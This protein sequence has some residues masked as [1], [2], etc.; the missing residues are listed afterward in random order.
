M[1]DQTISE[2]LSQLADRVPAPG[3]G[4]AA[5]LHAAQGAAL[6]GMVA[7]YTTGEKYAEHRDAV[8]RII[9]RTDTVRSA[10]LRVGEEDAAAFTAVI[11]AYRLP[12]GERA[13]A[14]AHAL[15]GAARPPAE[16]VGLARAVVELATEL[17]PIGNR[18]VITDIAAATEA[19]RA[20]ATT[21]RINVEINLGG[22]KDEALRAELTAVIATVDDIADRAARLTDAVRL[23]IAP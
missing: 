3:G 18:N 23:E 12:K 21:A 17:L 15:A 16:V 1:R 2:Y 22:I 19:A 10:A 7:R 4:A 8:E 14:V 9:A 5:A 6:L 13:E 11:D 20:A